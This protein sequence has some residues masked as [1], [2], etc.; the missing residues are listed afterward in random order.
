MHPEIGFWLTNDMENLSQFEINLFGLTKEVYEYEW[1]LGAAFFELVESPEVRDG[2]LKCSLRVERVTEGSF[3][4]TFHTEGTVVVSCDRCLDDMDLPICRDDRLVVKLGDS[5]L[6]DDDIITVP[7]AEGVCD[8]SSFIYQ[9]IM[10][11]IPIQHM[12]AP[13][14]CNAEMMA[15]LKEH[16]AD[17]RFEE[18]GEQEEPVNEMEQSGGKTPV[19]PRWSELMKLKNNN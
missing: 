7:D 19:D 1:V 14:K 2:S 16:L 5:Y 17:R 8:V 9:F 4:F 15:K 6:E 18:D 12:H 10:L 3:A 11:D 13:G